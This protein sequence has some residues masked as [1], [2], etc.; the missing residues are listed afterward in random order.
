MIQVMVD[1]NILVDYLA[2]REPFCDAARKLL[3]F[4]DMGDYRLWASSS[5]ITGVYNILSNGGAASHAPAAR[6]SLAS[7]RGIVRICP[8]GEDEVEWA[9]DSRW[10][11][12]EDALVY[13]AATSVGARCIVTR[14]ECDFALSSIPV[15][16]CDG[17][18]K[19][20]E[21]KSHLSYELVDL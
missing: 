18:F 17:F 3:V 4:A 5:Q 10:S 12:F 15:F 14:N 7:L 1:S 16:D 2:E 21:E 8:V 11:D 20:M 9:L 13:Q 6:R 19:W